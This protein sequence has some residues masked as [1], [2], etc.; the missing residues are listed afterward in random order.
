MILIEVE[1][2]ESFKSLSPEN[3]QFVKEN[4]DSFVYR[5]V[6]KYVKGQKEHGGNL[7]DRDCL[8][9][10]FLENIDLFW[11]LAAEKERRK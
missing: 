8:A 1:F 2:P 3:Q 11:Y 9:E 4:I 5:A 6:D 10:S 7:W